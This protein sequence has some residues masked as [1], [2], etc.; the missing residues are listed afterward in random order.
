VIIIV[1]NIVILLLLS[2]FANCNVC[3]QREWRAVH[4]SAAAAAAAAGAAG[5]SAAAE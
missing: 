5:G 4:I 1:A 3:C 2:L